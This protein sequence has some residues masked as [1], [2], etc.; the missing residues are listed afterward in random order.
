MVAQ[1]DPELAANFARRAASVSHDGEAIYGAQILAAMEAQ[2]FVE[3][4]LHTL[5]DTALRFI[6]PDS[7]IAPLIHDLRDWRIQERDWRKTRERIAANYGYDRYGGNCHIV[8][9]HALIMLS[10]LYGDDD[11]Q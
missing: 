3:Q 1:G 2:A 9:N 4:D 6:P 11:F 10:L 7:V 5:I 8:P